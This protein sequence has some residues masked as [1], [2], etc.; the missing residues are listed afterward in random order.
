MLAVA[1]VVYALAAL[2]LTLYHEAWR[3]EA[4]SWLLMR[5]G[6]VRVMLSET[7][8]AG[9]P[10][11][12]YLMLAPLTAA[13]LPFL[14]QQLLN[15][16]LIVSA[17]ALLLYR[18]PLHPALKVLF[19][20][21][22]YPLC[23]YAVKARPY[24]LVILLLFGVMAAW[25]IR[26][27]RPLVVAILVALLANA[28]V[29]GLLFGAV[30]G[31]VFLGD[32]L[33]RGTWRRGKTQIVIALMLAAGILSAWQLRLPGGWPVVHRYIDRGT[34]PWAIGTAFFPDLDP[35]F[36][37]AAGLLILLL[38]VLAIGYRTDA[39]L[40]LT[41]TIVLLLLLFQY[42]W[43]GGVRHTG[44]ILV[45]T[46][47]AVWMAGT[48]PPPEAWRTKAIL[49]FQIALALSLA[50]S[51]SM[52]AREAVSEVRWQY[53]GSKEMAAY[54]AAHVPLSTAIVATGAIPNEAV[55]PYL[56]RRRFWYAQT[57]RFG[58]YFNWD[59]LGTVPERKRPVSAAE[60]IEKGRVTF[61]GK[62]WLLLVSSE[63]GSPEKDGF[64]LLYTNREPIYAQQSERFWLY[65]PK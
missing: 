46:M 10:A 63:L 15:L 25:R 30:I 41:L 33:A 48:T 55:L 4:D 62:P 61:A 3:D 43:V 7:A 6:G 60:A 58:S 38:A 9:T 26:D 45:V 56:P 19:V 39:L 52:S 5:D 59:A 29:H 37:F 24:S 53:S 22:F 28:T 40:F 44:L 21:S 23:E 49:I 8:Y 64:R 42:I 65:A 47:A 16:L 13:G 35:R 50:E 14:A 57:G 1:L 36:S 11:L 54:I 51:V 17:M 18:A 27:D 12:W 34:I 32:A 20:L 31:A 2:T